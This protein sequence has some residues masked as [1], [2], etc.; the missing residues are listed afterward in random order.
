MS[1]PISG[2][3]A[4]VA[5]SHV[6]AASAT[7][8][9]GRPRSGSLPDVRV[10]EATLASSGRVDCVAGRLLSSASSSASHPAGLAGIEFTLDSSNVAGVSATLTPAT[11]P[12]T[13]IVATRLEPKVKVTAKK[14]ERAAL[15]RVRLFS[16]ANG[17]TVQRGTSPDQ[18]A[19]MQDCFEAVVDT[20]KDKKLIKEGV[21]H[22]NVNYDRNTIT[23]I[24][25]DGKTKEMSI[26]AEMEADPVLSDQ[27]HQLSQH[28]HEIH[29]T[30][31]YVAPQLHSKVKGLRNG[32]T[33]LRRSETDNKYRELKARLRTVEQQIATGK[34]LPGETLPRLTA[35]QKELKK[36][37]A[38]FVLHERIPKSVAKAK[39]LIGSDLS[40][41]SAV[42]A[43]RTHLAA[44]HLKALRTT[45][46]ARIKEKETAITATPAKS[47]AEIKQLEKELAALKDLQFRINEIDEYA[48]TMALAHCPN[49]GS[50]DDEIQQAV[51]KVRSSVDAHYQAAN[52]QEY[53]ER[54]VKDRTW[55]QY[56]NIIPNNPT[57]DTFKHD[58]SVDAAGLLYN[59]STDPSRLYH[60]HCLDHGASMKA[61]HFTDTMV[62]QMLRVAHN[63]SHDVAEA[64][65]QD[66]EGL[67]EADRVAIIAAIQAA[68]APTPAA[69]PAT[70]VI[71]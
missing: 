26:L 42:F 58:Y 7:I 34:P 31:S 9:G 53:N 12:N 18:S 29:G 39:E 21:K 41:A 19:T 10:L 37:I 25:T 65:S 67:A 55:G 45:T 1:G 15:D 49:P 2:F 33:A 22:I 27:M 61:P 62:A 68:K 52:Q 54:Q 71:I 3:A 44:N 20:L 24:D 8:G 13:R 38:T 6:A 64:L 16:N 5:P 70:P 63:P 35:E 36:K 30:S 50:S 66:L 51:D 43:E 60:Q 59:I 14:V 48:L 32:S 23:F 11:S 40:V 17:T 46:Q 56:F 47:P 28:A 4:S 57:L 69:A